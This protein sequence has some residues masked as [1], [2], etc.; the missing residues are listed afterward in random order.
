MTA[1]PAAP[2]PHTTTLS[3]RGSFLTILRGD[4]QLLAQACLDVEASG[5]GD[6]LQIDAAEG[7]S[8]QLHCF[9]DLVRVL[10]I[11]AE[12]EGVHAGQLLEE[13]GLAFHDRHGRLRADVAETQHRGAVRHHGHRVLLDG[14]G[15]GAL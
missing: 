5:G 14:E 9:H 13:H 11:E 10:G 3:R 12:G 2:T 1:V 8:N 7:G 15:E 4:V 6:V